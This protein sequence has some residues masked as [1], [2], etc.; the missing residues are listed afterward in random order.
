MIESNF[1]NK[2]CFQAVAI[3]VYCNKFED[4]LKVYEQYKANK[5][6]A[7][8]TD[9]PEEEI[10]EDIRQRKFLTEQQ[11]KVFERYNFLLSDL[12]PYKAI[13]K[14]ELKN[15]AIIF[16]VGSNIVEHKWQELKEATLKM[17]IGQNRG[18]K[19]LKK[20]LK[21]NFGSTNYSFRVDSM[22]PRLKCS[23]VFM[24]ELAKRTEIRRIDPTRH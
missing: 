1:D 11:I 20:T 16:H 12:L 10:R 3:L 5:G 17:D 15:D 21:L 7:L 2:V 13:K 6:Q 24:Q 8:K 18:Y 23:D 4:A 22:E 14:I 19:Y 9:W